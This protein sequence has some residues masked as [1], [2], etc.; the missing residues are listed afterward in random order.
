M[1]LGRVI[2]ERQRTGSDGAADDESAHHAGL[3]VRCA[4]IIVDALHSGRYLEGLF[5]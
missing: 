3:F 1:T 2:I 4:E 5:G